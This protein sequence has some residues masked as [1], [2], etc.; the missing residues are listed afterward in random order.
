MRPL[1]IL[2]AI[3]ALLMLPAIVAGEQAYTAPG[4]AWVRGLGPPVDIVA[5]RTTGWDSPAAAGQPQTP[6][7]TVD[8]GPNG[9]KRCPL[10]ASCRISNTTSQGTMYGSGTLVDVGNGHGLVVTCRHLYREGTGEVVC[11]FGGRKFKGQVVADKDGHD[12]SAILIQDPGVKPIEVSTVGLARGATAYSCGYGS[13]SYGVNT[14]RV[15]KV[16]SRRLQISGT[17]RDGDSGGPVLNSRGQLVGVLWGTDHQSYVECTSSVQTD[18]FLQRAG[19]YLLPWNAKINDPARDPRLQPP[20]QQQPPNI[21]VQ[22]PTVPLP[23]PV[24]LSPLAGEVARAHSRIDDVV[25]GAEKLAAK[26]EKEL[27]GLVT[28]IKAAKDKAAGVETTVA[29]ALD[30]ESPNGLPARILA[31]VKERFGTGLL[32]K[33]LGWAGVSVGGVAALLAVIGIAIALLR[34][35]ERKAMAGEPT[36]AQRFTART[37]WGWDDAAAD[38]EADALRWLGNKIHPGW[39]QPPPVAPASPQPPQ[40]I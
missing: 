7:Y 33:V 20:P 21:I 18:V 27:P 6:G 40:G 22:Q 13:G 5:P 37:P 3:A 16:D 2:A 9:C 12:L 38:K 10:A 24:D 28:D 39:Q 23:P 19:R 32:A 34:R 17:A 29:E 1:S 36:L 15:L 30:E 31:R 25:A 14:G 26:Y 4:N 35:G 11:D 8:C